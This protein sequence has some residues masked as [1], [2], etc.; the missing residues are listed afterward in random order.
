MVSR[1]VKKNLAYLNSKVALIYLKQEVLKKLIEL[2]VNLSDLTTATI[3]K[4]KLQE[5]N[6]LKLLK[7]FVKTKEIDSI[8]NNESK[9]EI[10]EKNKFLVIWSC[11]IR[12]KSVLL[13]RSFEIGT[14]EFP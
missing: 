7:C 4:T 5:T 14:Q 13:G 3:K 8:C 11:T 10:G 2:N 1:L 12:H 9:K 6:T